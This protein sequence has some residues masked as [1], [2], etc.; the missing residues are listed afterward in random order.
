[1]F[2][3]FNLS[4]LAASPDGLV[5]NDSIIKSK[6]PYSVKD[7][8]PSDAYKQNKF[9]CMNLKLE[10]LVLKRTHNYYYQVQGQLLIIK[11]KFWKNKMKKLTEFYVDYLIPEIIN[12]HFSP[13]K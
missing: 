9:K 11:K 2:V 13:Y 5:G 10:N 3:D 1:M 8:S 7:V 12:P 4:F 6:C